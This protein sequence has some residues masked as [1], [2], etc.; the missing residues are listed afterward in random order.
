M[1]AMCGTHLNFY[2]ICF[3]L[4]P[5]VCIASVFIGFSYQLEHKFGLIYV[6]NKAQSSQVIDK[7]RGRKKRSQNG[8]KMCG[9]KE[10]KVRLFLTFSHF[11]RSFSK[12]IL[13][14][15]LKQA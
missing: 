13:N 5:R 3:P 14:F 4:S 11:L 1:E 10:K 6:I 9:R 12:I 15:F 8:G 7:T 2:S